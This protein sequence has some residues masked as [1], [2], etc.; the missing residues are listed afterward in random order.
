MYLH[1]ST[2]AATIPIPITIDILIYVDPEEKLRGNSAR[3]HKI[4]DLTPL[5]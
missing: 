5:D 3:T 2:I 1:F 4:E